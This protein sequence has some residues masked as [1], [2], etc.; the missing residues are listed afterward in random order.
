MQT[1]PP[2][3]ASFF[4]EYDIARLNSEKDSFTIIERTL[5]FGNRSELRWLFS[6]YSRT[7][8]ADWVGR[9]GKERLPEPHR[10][11]WR[12]ILEINS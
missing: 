2:S 9:F 3:L 6:V 11:F 8:V 1:I 10:T 5:Q 12:I 4:Q 7:Q